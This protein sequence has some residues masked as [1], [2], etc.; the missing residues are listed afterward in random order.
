M[1]HDDRAKVISDTEY[2]QLKMS[3]LSYHGPDNIRSYNGITPSLGERVMIDPSAVVLGDLVMG[4]DVAF[5]ASCSFSGH[6]TS[7]MISQEVLFS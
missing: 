2:E 4:D 5:P 7:V 1:S 6:A 3:K